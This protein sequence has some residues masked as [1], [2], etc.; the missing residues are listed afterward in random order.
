MRR[1]QFKLPE[2]PPVLNSEKWQRQPIT[3][4]TLLPGRQEAGGW[5]GK[6]KLL[7]SGLEPGPSAPPQ[8][9]LLLAGPWGSSTALPPWPLRRPRQDCPLQ[10]CPL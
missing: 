7:F 9:A 3:V 4:E 8:P 2:T 10:L 1:K 5:E 6:W